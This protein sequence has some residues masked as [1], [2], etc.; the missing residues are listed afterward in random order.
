MGTPGTH[1]DSIR[2]LNGG[3][4]GGTVYVCGGY[5]ILIIDFVIYSGTLVRAWRDA[6]DNFADSERGSRG[7]LGQRGSCVHPS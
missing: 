2:L 1:S 4:F 7:S 6:V 3:H 5:V